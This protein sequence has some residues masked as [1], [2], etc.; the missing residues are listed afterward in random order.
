MIIYCIH[1]RKFPKASNWLLQVLP[2]GKNNF[3]FLI[4]MIDPNFSGPLT[5][6]LTFLYVNVQK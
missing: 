1:E 4:C 3:F 2:N 5:I 6:T